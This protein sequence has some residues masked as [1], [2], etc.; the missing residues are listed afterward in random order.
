MLPG[1]ASSHHFFESALVRDRFAAG[2]KGKPAG[3]AFEGFSALGACDETVGQRRVE[4]G[5]G[6]DPLVI[7]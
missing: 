7:R 2:G 3:I 1:Q 6:L 5:Q 4:F